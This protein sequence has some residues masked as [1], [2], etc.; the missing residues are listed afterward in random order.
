MFVSM[1][2][3]VVCWSQES[4]HLVMNLKEK[5]LFRREGSAPMQTLKCMSR[6]MRVLMILL[7]TVTPSWAG[8]Y[9]EDDFETHLG[10]N[11]DT[12]GMI[13]IGIPGCP[14]DGGNPGVSTDVA[15]S[16]THSLKGDYSCGKVQCGTYIHR[17]HTPTEEV[18]TRF[19]YRTSNFT[20]EATT[21]TKHFQ[22]QDSTYGAPSF[23]WR[24]H[25]GSRELG[26]SSQVE[27]S[28]CANGLG[29][30]DGCNYSPNV[31]SVPLNDNQWYCIETH[32]KMNT[33]GVAN[34]VL[35]LW[36]NGLL[37]MQYLD[38][39]FRGTEVK[40]PIGNS[41]QAHFDHVSIY[42]Q[43]GF[44]IMYYDLFAVGSTRIGCVGSRDTT[45]PAAPS[46]PTIR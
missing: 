17:F 35:E 18:Y 26:V 6:A 23:W 38:R 13:N 37:T 25:Y 8:T 21:G 9:W 16:G 2:Q 12:C 4:G 45:S 30:Y 5:S 46:G 14:K 32:I 33:P 40:G 19:Y 28:I 34:G 44:G 10:P 36:V 27:A 1:G 22:Q 20:Y 41:S 3:T 29:P 43:A 7:L 39:T 24:N 15:Y 31:A 11:W 42:V